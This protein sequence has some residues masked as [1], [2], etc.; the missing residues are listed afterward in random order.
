[1][2][3]SCQIIIRELCSLL[4]LYYG[5]QNSILICKRAVVA[6]YHVVWE[7]VVEQWLGVRRTVGM[8]CGAVARCASYC[9]NV[10]WGSG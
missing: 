4:K 3:R 1:M 5:I 8:C 2:F 7:C 6:A 10:L 9:G